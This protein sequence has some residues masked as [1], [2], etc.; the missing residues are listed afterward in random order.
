MILFFLIKI[1]AGSVL[2]FRLNQELTNS[3]GVILNNAFL[4]DF[5]YINDIL[6]LFG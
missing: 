5:D 3:F 6:I 2:T 1:S 4:I